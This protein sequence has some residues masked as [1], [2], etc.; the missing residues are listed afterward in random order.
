MQRF[1]CPPEN[2][3]AVL[4]AGHCTEAFTH[5]IK[6]EQ[7]S[8]LIQI[9]GGRASGIKLHAAGSSLWEDSACRLDAIR[10]GLALYR[11]AVKVTAPLVEVRESRGPAGYSGFV[12]PRHGV[13]LCGYY[14]GL[15]P[16]PCLINGRQS[17]VLEVGMQSS[18]VETSLTDKMGDEVVLIGAGLEA[19]EIGTAWKTS[20]QQALVSLLRGR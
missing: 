17:R 4:L 5:A 11:G 12:T 16:G 7:V 14:Q 19:D 10:P 8:R 18:F 15:R 20:P 6:P 9:V 1:A 13:I 2:V 3:A